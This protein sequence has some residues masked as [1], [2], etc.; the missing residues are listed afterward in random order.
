MCRR[1]HQARRPPLAKIRPGRKESSAPRL[2]KVA[3]LHCGLTMTQGN[4]RTNGISDRKSDS[5]PNCEHH[6]D[7]RH[8][9]V[10]PTAQLLLKQSADDGGVA[11][12]EEHRQ[13]R[14][15]PEGQHRRWGQGQAGLES[16]HQGMDISQSAFY[17]RDQRR[18]G[19]RAGDFGRPAMSVV[20]TTDLAP[21]E[22]LQKMPVER[23]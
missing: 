23:N 8:T 18:L 20:P 19:L 5:Q 7:F 1:R 15:G 21:A 2:Y 16:Q 4:S 14:S 3:S 13:P 11:R 6:R 22:R 12:G 10:H 9:L 17:S